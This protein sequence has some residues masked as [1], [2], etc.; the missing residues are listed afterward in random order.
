M[1]ILNLKAFFEKEAKNIVATQKRLLSNK[2]G[3]AMDFA[4]HNA[5]STA[6][7][8]GFDHWLK[9]TDET[10][11][12]AFQYETAP[13]RMTLYASDKPHSGKRMYKGQIKQGKS[14]P[15]FEQLIE[16]HTDEYSGFYKGIPA[17]SQ[18]GERLKTEI[19]RQLDVTVKTRFK[20]F[21]PK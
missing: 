18:F 1:E 3:V 4:P 11:K 14:H 12:N 19:H 20:K 5:V 9:A 15:K 13:N 2:K 8:K 6:K 17:G 16:W 7:A 10:R 21:F